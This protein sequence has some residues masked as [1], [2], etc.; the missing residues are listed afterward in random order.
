MQ[1]SMP[2]RSLV[3]RD[4]VVHDRDVLEARIGESCVLFHPVA[5]TY[6]DLAGSGTHV[7]TLLAEP[8]DIDELVGTLS[9]HYAVDAQTC[10]RDT[11]AF[12]HSLLDKRF[13]AVT[14]KPPVP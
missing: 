8:R 5:G 3:L 1:D 4:R 9:S 14:A 6:C 10:E 12:L 7:W 11:L 13:I 2:A